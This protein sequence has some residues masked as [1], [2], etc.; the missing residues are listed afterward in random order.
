MQKPL[1]RLFGRKAFTAV[2]MAS[3]VAALAGVSA[4]PAGATSASASLTSGSLAF[5]SV[6]AVSF[7]ATLNGLDQTATT[8]QG[9]DVSDATGSGA[10]WN[11]TA[12]STTFTAGTHTL[13][14]AATTVQAAPAVA[15]DTSATC[16]TATN[17]IT[18]P[19]ALPAGATAP[20]A[21]KLVNAAVN[22]GMGN[23]TV[24][25]TW[26]LAIPGNAYSGSYA[27]TWTLTLASAP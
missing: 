27:S 4:A 3:V 14:N 20:T 5:L 12:T 26:K 18:Y 6:P 16:T 9:I 2:V 23:Q 15:C 19:Y 10:G 24:T 1:N 25:P 17:S 8:T 13:S 21:T 22:T 11:I 7:S